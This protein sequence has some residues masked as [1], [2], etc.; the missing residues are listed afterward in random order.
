MYVLGSAYVVPCMLCLLD[1]QGFDY[2]FLTQKVV[3]LHLATLY[4][5]TL[6]TPGVLAE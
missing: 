1:I 2:M 4:C 5:Q 3:A 6:P